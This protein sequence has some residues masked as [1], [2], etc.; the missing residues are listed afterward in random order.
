[1]PNIFDIS[2]TIFVTTRDKGGPPVVGLKDFTLMQDEQRA[3]FGALY[4]DFAQRRADGRAA[5]DEQLAAAAEV[6]AQIARAAVSVAVPTV[7]VVLPGVPAE[8]TPVVA[9][10]VA[11][12]I[13]GEVLPKDAPITI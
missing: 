11:A 5:A 9:A 2:F 8:A 13:V 6:E 10:A 12:P 4:L 7:A 3:E 1:M